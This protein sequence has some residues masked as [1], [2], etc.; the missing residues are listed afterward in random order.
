M[1]AKLGPK[2]DM[3]K[4]IKKRQEA[5][6]P[7]RSLVQFADYGWAAIQAAAQSAKALRHK[8]IADPELL[9]LMQALTGYL[10]WLWCVR[11][12]GQGRV[13]QPYQ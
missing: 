9:S 6:A 4:G 10:V 1:G 13:E 7:C 5:P 2:P 8:A 11:L 12:A 3:A